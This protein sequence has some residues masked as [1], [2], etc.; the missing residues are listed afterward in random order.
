MLAAYEARAR[1]CRT[2]TLQATPMAENI[3][4]ALGFRDL[5]LILEY[6][7]A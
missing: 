3:Y 5:G 4:A 6:T 2:A 1:G 7:Q